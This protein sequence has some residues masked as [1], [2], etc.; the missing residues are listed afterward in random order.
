[1]ASSGTASR[2]TRSS[3]GLAVGERRTEVE[4]L[5][6]GRDDQLIGV[7]STHGF[8]ERTRHW[9]GGGEGVVVERVDAGVLPRNGRGKLGKEGFRRRTRTELS[10]D[11]SVAGGE[12]DTG[13]R[14]LT[15][16]IVASRH[17]DC[18]DTNTTERRQHGD[19]TTRDVVA[20]VGSSGAAERVV[21][22]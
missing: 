10:D 20:E 7:G 14:N 9:R 19:K 6:V 5:I 4:A 18:G 15:S 1:M 8:D 3:A 21:A 12:R 11:S 2:G 16:E 22:W 13:E 17:R